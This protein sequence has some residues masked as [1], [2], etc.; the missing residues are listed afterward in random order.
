MQ[1]SYHKALVPGLYLRSREVSVLNEKRHVFF[2]QF[3]AAGVT[4]V[5]ST[6]PGITAVLPRSLLFVPLSI[7]CHTV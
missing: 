1:I 4:H 7:R 2:R 3:L 5:A 6:E